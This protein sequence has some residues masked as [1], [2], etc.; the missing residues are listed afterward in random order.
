M[1]FNAHNKTPSTLIELIV[2]LAIYGLLAA[3]GVVAYNGYTEIAR[4]SVANQNFKNQV[5]YFAH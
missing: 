1:K 4:K 5:K 2:V 3:V